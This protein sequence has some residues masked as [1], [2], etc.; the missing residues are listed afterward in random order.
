[1]ILVWFIV[2]MLISLFK[3][4][5][6]PLSLFLKALCPHSD[7]V[8]VEDW[9]CLQL[10]GWLNLLLITQ[11]HL[12]NVSFNSERQSGQVLCYPTN[13]ALHGSKVMTSHGVVLN[14]LNPHY[15]GGIFRQTM[16]V[17]SGPVFLFWKKEFRQVF[18]LVGWLVGWLVGFVV[19]VIL[20]LFFWLCFV[21]FF[22]FLSI[23][24][25]S[26]PDLRKII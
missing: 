23:S 2:D 18:L 14:T 17:S 20:F 24:H 25:L 21:C 3:V 8:E 19:V 15:P 9:S 10:G 16:Q 5:Q 4:I 7:L 22:V 6:V 1:M 26:A 13:F 11:S 12:G